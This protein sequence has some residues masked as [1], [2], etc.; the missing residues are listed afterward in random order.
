MED[1]LKI[2]TK[3]TEKADE[4]Q[5]LVTIS[6]VADGLRHTIMILEE[7]SQAI[8][9]LKKSNESMYAAAQIEFICSFLASMYVNATAKNPEEAKELMKEFMPDKVVK[10]NRKADA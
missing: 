10:T 1:I 5:A 3:I 2:F 8:A 7:E 9:K 6:D 4:C